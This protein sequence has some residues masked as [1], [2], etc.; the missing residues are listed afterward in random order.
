M[1]ELI[2]K[3]DYKWGIR[4]WCFN[5][6]LVVDAYDEIDGVVERNEE[7]AWI[8]DDMS[9]DE[10]KRACKDKYTITAYKDDEL[11]ELLHDIMTRIPCF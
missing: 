3:V 4:Y 11:D 5:E 9:F 6:G 7:Q 8:F 10:L 2:A 1:Y